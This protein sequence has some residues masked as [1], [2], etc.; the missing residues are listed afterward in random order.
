MR[1]ICHPRA[2]VKDGVSYVCLADHFDITYVITPRLFEDA[3]LSALAL[4]AWV[5]WKD[6]KVG[7]S[8]YLDFS[9]TE[10][11]QLARILDGILQAARIPAERPEPADW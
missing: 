6:I 1:S 4:S 3:E 11:E 10:N 2:I 9:D 7:Y 8:P 5:F